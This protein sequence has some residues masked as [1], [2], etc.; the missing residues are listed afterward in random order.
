MTLLVKAEISVTKMFTTTDT[1]CRHVLQH[2]KCSDWFVLYL[3]FSN[4]HNYT[5]KQIL[6]YLQKYFSSQSRWRSRPYPK[7][8]SAG[9]G[10]TERKR[11]EFYVEE[12]EIYAKPPV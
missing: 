6:K 9:G 10:D 2:C 5:A 12:E 11:K 1:A 3:L 7:L 4:C 8:S